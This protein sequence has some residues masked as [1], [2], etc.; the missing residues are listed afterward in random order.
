MSDEGG[1]RRQVLKPLRPVWLAS[2]YVAYMLL[3]WLVR[4]LWPLRVYGRQHLPKSGGYVL[5]PAHVQAIDPMFVLV[6]RGYGRVK[7]AMIMAKEELFGKSSVIDFLWGIFGAF[8]VKRGSGNQALIR[9]VE[10]EVQSGRSLLIFPEGTRT[11]GGN[12]GVLGRLKSG[13][14]VVARQAGVPIVPCRIR[15]RAGAFKMFRRVT[16]VYGPPVSLEELG[17]P[18]E[19]SPR[20]IR[21]AKRVFAGKLEALFAEYKDRM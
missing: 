4:I 21:E 6:G 1:A 12:D 8:P 20:D 5:A 3:V 13:A 2:Y 17:L 15:Y 11:S 16:V 18:E 14:F 9:A 10:E 19:Y 7:E